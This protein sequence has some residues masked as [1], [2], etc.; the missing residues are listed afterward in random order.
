M[1]CAMSSGFFIGNTNQNPTPTESS[2]PL[3]NPTLFDHLRWAVAIEIHLD[4]AF[5]DLK[6]NTR[7]DKLTWLVTCG[8]IPRKWFQQKNTKLPHFVMGCLRERQIMNQIDL[9]FAI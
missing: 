2:S 6:A 5:R 3:Q 4:K 9:Q 8:G 1:H 7:G